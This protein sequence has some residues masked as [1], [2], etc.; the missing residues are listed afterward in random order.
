MK[1][2]LDMQVEHGASHYVIHNE[3]L[4]TCPG[5]LLGREGSLQI[6]I[7]CGTILCSLWRYCPSCGRKLD[8]PPAAVG[9]PAGPQGEGE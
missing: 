2:T 3:D 4:K 1:S 8:A 9:Q 6:Y 7:P 5:N